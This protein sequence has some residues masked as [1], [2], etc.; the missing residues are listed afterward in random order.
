[1][2]SPLFNQSTSDENAIMDNSKEMNFTGTEDEATTYSSGAL[3]SD[4][5]DDDKFELETKL[6][7][8]G[9]RSQKTPM[10]QQQQQQ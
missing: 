4:F 1:M 9:S 3:L 8:L 5:D 2:E 6:S 7:R 10:Q